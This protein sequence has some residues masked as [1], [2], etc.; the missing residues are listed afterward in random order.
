VP[1]DPPDAVFPP[2]LV[3]P[4]L[5]EV[6]PLLVA[7]P[8]T[9]VPPVLEVP[10]VLAPPPPE[11]PQPATAMLSMPAANVHFE[12]CSF[13]IDA[14]LCLGGYLVPKCRLAAA[15]GARIGPTK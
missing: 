3:V 5:L 4:P 13:L 2:L 15:R 14:L 11:L 12:R 9:A 10:P 6:P 7:P 1:F 8:D